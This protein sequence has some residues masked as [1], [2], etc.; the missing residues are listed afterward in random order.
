MECNLELFAHQKVSEV[1]RN[2]TCEVLVIIVLLGVKRCNV[3]A[4]L[5]KRQS[6]HALDL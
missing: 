3:H 4:K 2:N 6:I 1:K 5:F